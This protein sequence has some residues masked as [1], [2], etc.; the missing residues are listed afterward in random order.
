MWWEKCN[1]VGWKKGSKGELVGTDMSLAMI[2][3]FI[4][5]KK[6]VEPH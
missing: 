1:F 2:K 4:Q 5:K 6:K 3:H